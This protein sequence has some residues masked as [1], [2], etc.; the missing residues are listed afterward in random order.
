MTP[1]TFNLIV[2]LVTISLKLIYSQNILNTVTDSVNKVQVESKSQSC[3]KSVND[4][5]KTFIELVP[6]SII[7]EKLSINKSDFINPWSVYKP[8][9]QWDD[10]YKSVISLPGHHQHKILKN[11]IKRLKLNEGELR[12][13]GIGGSITCG[14]SANPQFVQS[15]QGKNSTWPKFLGDFLSKCYKHNN[16]TVTNICSGGVGTTY[17]VDQVGNWK[18]DP[19]HEIHFADIIIIDSALNDRKVRQGVLQDQ[20]KVTEMIYGKI[21]DSITQINEIFI[22]ELLVVNKRA[23][24]LLLGASSFTNQPSDAISSQMNVTVPYGILHIDMMHAFQA[25]TT[26]ER[27]RWFE[28]YRSDYIHPTISGNKVIAFYIFIILNLNVCSELDKTRHHL[29]PNLKLCENEESLPRT[30]IDDPPLYVSKHIAEIYEKG[31]PCF[32]DMTTPHFYP[33]NIWRAT[34]KSNNGFYFYED[35]HSKP[36]FIGNTTG[37]QF[38]LFYDASTVKKYVKF[39]IIKIAYLETYTPNVG[40]YL[41]QISTSKTEIVIEDVVDCMNVNSHVSITTI[42]QLIFNKAIV[43][44]KDIYMRIL[45]V[46]SSSSR[47]IDKVKLFGVTLY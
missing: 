10:I 2:F 11:K 28:V 16:I 46:P 40:T 33:F 25:W 27:N 6:D 36:G 22:R 1:R 20:S 26:L 3:S 34:L 38:E 7:I 15:P 19:T 14:H 47:N 44:G 24:I 4:T 41:V 17:W 29:F 43:V 30:N 13:L 37:N 32:I 42:K 5:V 45:I 31:R 8:I 9:L 39:G 35:V 21:G 23:V 18:L 12:I